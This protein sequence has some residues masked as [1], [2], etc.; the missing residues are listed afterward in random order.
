V[1]DKIDEEIRELRVELAQGDNHKTRAELGDVL[2]SLAQ[3][4]RHLDVD[5]EEA[6]REA[7][8]KFE[9]RF[10]HMEAQLAR[11]GREPSQAAADE[12][13]SLWLLAKRELG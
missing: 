3:L 7:D 13:E 6:L 11:Q 9:R 10:R 8:A 1:L 2:F 4:A 12:L 5:A